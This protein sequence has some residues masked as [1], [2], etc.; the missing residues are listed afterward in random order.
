MA[1]AGFFRGTNVNSD[2]RFSDK[3]LKLLK[4]LRFPPEFEKKVD[5][6]KVK[7]EV[8][9][10]WINTRFTELNGF[11][12]EIVA[13]M[14]V[15]LLEDKENPMPDPRKIQIQ[16]QGFLNKNAP[17]FMSELW[18]LLLDAQSNPH[19][20]PQSMIDEQKAKFMAGGGDRTSR[21]DQEV[22]AE[23]SEIEEVGEASGEDVDSED[24][25]VGDTMDLHQGGD[26]PRIDVLGVHLDDALGVR[27]EDALGAHLEGATILV[28]DLGLVHLLDVAIAHLPLG[29]AID[30]VAGIVERPLVDQDQGLHPGEGENTPGTRGHAQDPGARCQEN[31]REDP[32]LVRPCRSIA[33]L[34]R[35]S[36]ASIRVPATEAR[37]D[38]TKVER[39]GPEL[40]LALHRENVALSRRLLL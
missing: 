8:L 2:S 11:E 25:V 32:P 28:E 24:E 17:V 20:I 29:V 1:D 14:I 6:R 33:I 12:D 30:H 22:V 23:I 13:S 38:G 35:R 21:F 36:S 19:G 18:K 5:M 7:L 4:T 27:L 9:K 16:V 34:P 10:P 26:F 39:G 15:G 37:H 40:G 31:E 3:E